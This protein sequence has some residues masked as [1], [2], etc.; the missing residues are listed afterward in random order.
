MNISVPDVLALHMDAIAYW[1]GQ[2]HVILHETG[3]LGLVEANHGYNYQ[4]WHAE[5]R[6]RR[7]DKGF[8]F[9]YLAKRDI[10]AFNQ[11]RNDAMEAIDD[12]LYGALQPVQDGLCPV[13]SETPGMMI[14]RLS[15]L[16]LKYFHMEIQTKREG[17]DAEHRHTC[18]EKW[19][20][21]GKQKA[22][23]GACLGS[24]LQEVSEGMRTFHLYRQC[25]MY[26]DPMLNPELYSRIT[27]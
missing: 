16:A 3:F 5:D 8:E 23:L 10:D 22:Q 2:P 7:D 19:K 9:V 11:K 21:I 25:K 15:I 26:N 17:V 14:D 6:A 18:T 1:K 20:R 27:G 24:L 12:Y 13:H 4:L